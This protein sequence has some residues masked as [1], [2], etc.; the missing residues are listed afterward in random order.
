[1]LRRGSQLSLSLL[2]AVV[3]ML[4]DCNDV[5]VVVAVSSGELNQES[6]DPTEVV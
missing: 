5:V 2:L 1:M 6:L 4:G 3:V